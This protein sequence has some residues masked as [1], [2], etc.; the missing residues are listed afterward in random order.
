MSEPRSKILARVRKRDG[1]EAPFERA[2]I[3]DAVARA[4]AAVGEEDL[5]FADEVSAVVTLTLESR[6][7][8]SAADENT[9]EIEDIQ[10]LVEQALIGMGRGAVAKAYILYRDRRTRV[11][12][13]LRIGPDNG[14]IDPPRVRE[15]DR[16]APWSKGRIVAA[17][18]GE[19]DLPRSSA[20]EVA[21]RVEV[22]VF[23]SG[24][25]WISSSLIRELV[26]NELVNMGLSAA[27]RR[28]GSVGLPRFD[29]RRLLR[30][31][32]LHP[33]QMPSSDGEVLESEP[34]VEDAISRELLRRY[35][36]EEVFS[37]ATVER[38]L[39]GEFSIEDL[40]RPHLYLY[41]ALPA[42]LLLVGEPTPGAA[43][44]L[45][46]SLV[47]AAQTT[48]RG[49]VLEDPGTALAPLV[50]ATRAGSSVGLAAWLRA[51]SSAATAC[52]RSLDI[53]SPGARYTAFAARLVEA[54][55]AMP[56]GLH[57]PRLFLHELEL[58]GLAT[59]HPGM[60][61]VLEE[62]LERGRLVPTWNADDADYVGPGCTRLPRERSAVACG[63][64]VALNLVRVARQAGPWREER[65]LEGLSGLVHCA[66]EACRELDTFQ[67]AHQAARP[68]AAN[69]RVSFALVPVGLREALRILGGGEIDTTQGARI[70]GF[71][72]EAA[73]RFS[74]DGPPMQLD[75]YFGQG[76][77]A[78]LAQLDA[79]RAA[80]EGAQQGMLF[81][82]L[83][84]GEWRPYSTGYRLSPVPGLFAGAG[85][86]E[87]L[88]TVP[89]GALVPVPAAR[90]GGVETPRLAALQRFRITRSSEG[91]TDRDWLFPA[92][93]AGASARGP[94]GLVRSGTTATT[95][96][97]ADEESPRLAPVH[98]LKP[99]DSQGRG[100]DE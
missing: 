90:D 57:A 75:P 74:A 32:P 76:A 54:L 49:V 48:S 91:H 21:A 86:G 46:E 63:G 12:D 20:E 24:L 28:Q 69:A 44:E 58:E 62:L 56:S 87:C 31:I 77:G 6:F 71:L 37:D 84:E 38:H 96:T 15:G 53:G 11:R 72:S 43:F 50:R 22:R 67:R 52:G 41:S 80:R 8:E 95:T 1:R 97:D 99:R 10:D 25:R 61:S 45:I 35:A 93:A 4:Q 27:L 89:A 59:G 36:L 17:L 82:G 55:A 2:K 78:R 100:S 33:W 3:R 73:R 60:R 92:Q 29:V 39:A 68:G 85:E 30:R 14:D 83:G 26:D 81:E 47:R 5:Q 79:D 66:V 9:P 23:D 65:A 88:A 16:S 70:I 40:G 34:R 19:A 13:A 98:H 18:M 42:E 7:A 51:L 64:A 94:R